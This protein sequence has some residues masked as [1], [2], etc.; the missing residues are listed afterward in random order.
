M[1]FAPSKDFI[2]SAEQWLCTIKTAND[3]LGLYANPLFSRMLGDL[4]FGI[5]TRSGELGWWT[6]KTFYQS[7]LAQWAA[8][9]FRH[10][11]KFI[12]KCSLSLR[13]KNIAQPVVGCA[14]L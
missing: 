14:D 13:D 12:I 5:C 2:L 9:S 7:P 11:L 4:W 10:K 1:S 6:F 3:K 8:A